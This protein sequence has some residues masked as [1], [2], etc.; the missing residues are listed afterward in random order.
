MTWVG[1]LWF[2][3]LCVGIGRGPNSGAVAW[4]QT[5]RCISASRGIRSK[6]DPQN[7]A[8]F[9]TKTHTCCIQKVSDRRAK[10]QECKNSWQDFLALAGVPQQ[11][12][13]M[14]VYSKSA[15]YLETSHEQPIPTLDVVCAEWGTPFIQYAGGPKWAQERGQLSVSVPVIIKN[16]MDTES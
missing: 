5:V 3:A 2:F 7:G 1:R 15:A 13:E 12:F 8:A 11:P 9:G 16:L 10:Q 14:K 6:S 4:S